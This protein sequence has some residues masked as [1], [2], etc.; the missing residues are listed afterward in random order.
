MR[1]RTEEKRS[2]I[3]DIAARV[4]LEEGYERASMSEIAA[5]VGGSKT[6]LYGYF[7]SK[8][9]LF[10][11]VSFAQAEKQVLPAF[12]ALQEDPADLRA[13]LVRAGAA[14]IGFLVSA[15]SIAAHRMV[16]GE[17]GRSDIGRRFY[18]G[19]PRRGI[20]YMTAFLSR[21]NR[22]GRIRDCDFEVA[23]T[24]LLALIESEWVPPV[25]YGM[26]RSA[27]L[28]SEL[29]A[30]TERAVDAFLAAYAT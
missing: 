9:E 3:L 30:S 22:A 20:G 25:L 27:P 6:T 11:A 21:A 5:R 18:E 13:A 2:D 8:E 7:K 14:L 28:P 24:H 1:V 15:E 12:D 29:R 19:G 10:M 26:A 17:A 23:A 4:F 16:L